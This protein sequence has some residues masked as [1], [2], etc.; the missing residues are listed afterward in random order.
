VV[1]FHR[2]SGP[3]A[4]S[5]RQFFSNTAPETGGILVSSYRNVTANEFSLRNSSAEQGT[6]TS[7]F[8][9]VNAS[10]TKSC[11]G[12]NYDFTLKQNCLQAFLNGVL[13]K[14]TG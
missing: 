11:I 1:L 6:A 5:V 13:C 9:N 8:C 3:T 2:F 10:L 7:R 4:H 14:K 12:L